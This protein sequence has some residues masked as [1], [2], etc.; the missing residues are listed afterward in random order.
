MAKAPSSSAKAPSYIAVLKQYGDSPENVRAYFKELPDLIKDSYSY[1]VALAYLFL[2]TEKAQ[3]RALYC[4]VVKR[5]RAAKVLAQSAID[6]EH[7]TRR[8][9]LERYEIVFGMS[10]PAV[11]QSKI[12]E[13]K[14]IR[15]RVIHGKRNVTDADM[16]KAIVDV[17]DYAVALNSELQKVAGFQPF[18]DLRGFKGAAHS[19]DKSTTRWLLKGMGFQLA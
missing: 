13:A 6:N 19:L 18:G 15:D 8:G 1:E 16:R 5:H 17:I 7:L 3:N 11:I 4:G 2:R 14:K 10:L 9:F 12:Q